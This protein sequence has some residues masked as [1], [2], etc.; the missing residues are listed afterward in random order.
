MNNVQAEKLTKFLNEEFPNELTLEQYYNGECYCAIGALMAKAKPDFVFN[1]LL[2]HLANTQNIESIIDGGVVVIEGMTDA[3][4]AIKDEFGLSDEDLILIQ[5]HNDSFCGSR[6]ER[7]EMI[8]GIIQ[9]IIQ[10]KLA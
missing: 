6:K 5:D 2:N 3:V 9:E 8:K 7:S 1:D 4:E 10:N